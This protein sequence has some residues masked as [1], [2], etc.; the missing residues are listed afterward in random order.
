MTSIGSYVFYNCSN[1]KYNEYNN[2]LY[3]GNDL[4]PYCCLVK[5]KSTDIT[6]CEINKNCKIVCPSAFRDCDILTSVNIECSISLNDAG[7]FFT[8]DNF[9]YYVLNKDSV[10]VSSNSYTGDVVIPESVTA[11]NTFVVSGIQAQ[12]FINSSITSVTIPNSVKSIESEAFFGCSGLTSITIPDSVTCIGSDAF[13]HCS[14][15]ISATIG[16]SVTYIKG[17]AF[18]GCGSLKT[19]YF[20]A[21]NCSSMY[22]GDYPIFEDCSSFNT[23]IIGDNVE[24]IPDYAFY[25]CRSITSVTIPSTIKKI[26]ESAFGGCRNIQCSQYDNALYIGNEEN[27]YLVLVSGIEGCTE[28]EVNT[29]C[30]HINNKAFISGLDLGVFYEFWQMQRLISKSTVPPLLSGGLDVPYTVYVPVESVEVYKTSQWWSEKNILPCILNVTIKSNDI[31]CGIVSGGGNYNVGEVAKLIATPVENCYF[32]KWSDGDT[33][34]PRTYQ[35][36]NDTTITAIFEVGVEVSTPVTESA[37]NAVN[38]YAHGNTIIVENATD[39]IFIYDAMG[40]LVGRDD[41]HI[42]SRITVNGTGVYI[43][44]TGG[45]VKRVMVN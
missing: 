32:V 27:P 43:V 15:L 41:V 22:N 7:L 21:Q 19:V 18:R 13:S 23:L 14:S 30:K 31:N 26:G 8:K 44:K 42:V 5:A 3:L 40:R 37:A 28:C 9:R 2:A 10:L 25:R 20:N 16:N 35:V 1:L 29:N 24:T 6:S 33:S 17:W 36:Y 39:E 12:A 45:M 4:N 11:G 38:I 34:N